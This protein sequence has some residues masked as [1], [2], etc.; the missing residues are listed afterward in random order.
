MFF[1][2][3]VVWIGDVGDGA[4]IL[5]HTSYYDELVMVEYKFF[6]TIIL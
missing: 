6:T 2:N 1:K 4:C 5:N 3:D